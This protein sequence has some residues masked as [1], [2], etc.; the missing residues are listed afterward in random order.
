MSTSNTAV[1]QHQDDFQDDAS[2]QHLTA[3]FNPV[4]ANRERALKQIR[5]QTMRANNWSPS[6]WATLDAAAGI[7][8][9]NS[10]GEEELTAATPMPHRMGID[11]DTDGLD[12]QFIRGTVMDAL[13]GAGFSISS[14]LSTYAYV[15][16]LKSGRQEAETA[17]SPRS[18]TTQDGERNGLDG[19]PL[20]VTY[21][22]YELDGRQMEVRRAYGEDPE[23]RP[24]REARR[25]LNREEHDTLYNG[26]GGQFETEAGVFTVGGLDSGNTDKVLQARNSSGWSNAQNVLSDIDALHDTIEQQSTPVD[27]NDVP[28][29]SK[30]GAYVMVPYTLWGSVMR[31][32]YET[33]ATD[34]PLITRLN[35]KYPYLT[36][37]PAPRLNGDHVIMLL[38]DSRYFSIVVGQGV[39]NTS[40][41]VDGGVA[42]KY[43][44]V[45]SRVPW[46][47]AQPD[48][49]QGIA[50]L[51][52]V[53]A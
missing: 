23:E 39:T 29:V 7:Q 2:A 28:L 27:E 17:M 34:E 20:P 48:G 6:A 38:N 40:W 51:T 53:N 25:A 46:V 35:R 9:A 14:S 49:I 33:Q 42:T 41:D 43:R 30:T 5:A 10:D 50:R 13:I 37:V 32:D 11:Y 36:W 16:P 22:T 26:W 31:E 21:S 52:G 18:D 24:A 3:F 8:P 45:S 47:R 19:V 1:T 15:R 4:K 12:E 44:L